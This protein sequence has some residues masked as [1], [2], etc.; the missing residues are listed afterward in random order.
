MPP[1]G[2]YENFE[3]TA[4]LGL[5]IY[6]HDRRELFETACR[7]LCAQLTDPSIVK[8]REKR[9][10]ELTAQNREELLRS[11]LAELLYLLNGTGWLAS[12][13]EIVRLD[14]T[15][16]RA[17][18]SG[19]PLDTAQHEIRMEIK[20]VTWHKL[21]IINRKDGSLRASVVFDV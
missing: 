9:E 21:E 17:V 14:D 19:E 6:G 18:V 11:W 4:D 10:I 2:G 16:L 20:A 5:Y 7:A 3:H 1:S 8:A 15:G 13:A 12:E